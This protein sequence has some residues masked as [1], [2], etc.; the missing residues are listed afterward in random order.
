MGCEGA[1]SMI[2]VPDHPYLPLVDFLWTLLSDLSPVR[3]KYKSPIVHNTLIPRGII[4]W[5]CV[6]TMRNHFALLEGFALP[7]L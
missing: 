4:I 6:A 2:S 3:N 1:F 5:R 7:G